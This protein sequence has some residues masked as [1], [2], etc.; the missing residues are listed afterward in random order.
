MKPLIKNSVIVILLFG[1]TIY[2]SSCKKEMIQEV[3][4]PAVKTSAVSDITQTSALTGGTVTNDGDAPVTEYGICWS[5]SPKPTISTNK[6]K[7]GTGIGSFTLSLDGL[8]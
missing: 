4:P 7:I 2:L 3:I 5:P 6:K 1:T 8:T